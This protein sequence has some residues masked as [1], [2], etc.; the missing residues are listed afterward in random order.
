LI[1]GSDGIIA[2]SND[3]YIDIDNNNDY[4]GNYLFVTADNRFKNLLTVKD[5]GNVGIVLVILM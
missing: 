3:L 5:N 1:S 4:S 2:G